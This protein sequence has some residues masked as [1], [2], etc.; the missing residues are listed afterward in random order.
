MSVRS[1]VKRIVNNCL[2]A[3]CLS[4]SPS[5]RYARR[6]VGGTTREVIMEERNA[7]DGHP[8][9]PNSN[10]PNM[11]NGNGPYPNAN[12]TEGFTRGTGPAAQTRATMPN[13]TSFPN[14][15]G[16][17]NA[18]SN[19]SNI[20]ATLPNDNRRTSDIAATNKAWSDRHQQ[21]DE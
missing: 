3:E 20:R 17:R 9:K 10:N 16:A 13:S 21:S 5:K 2:D 18:Y 6:T 19:H 14:S 8:N 7:I 4:R 11:N 1:V 15:L 12:H